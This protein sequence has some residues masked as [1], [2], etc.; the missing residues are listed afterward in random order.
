MMVMIVA[1]TPL[2]NA[3]SQFLPISLPWRRR[4]LRPTVTLPSEIEDACTLQLETVVHQMA[5]KLSTA[6]GSLES[7]KC[8]L[9]PP[10]RP[11]RR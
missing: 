9:I 4:Y 10:S 11:I 1:T 2:L 7:E 5:N 8:S 3:S 6:P